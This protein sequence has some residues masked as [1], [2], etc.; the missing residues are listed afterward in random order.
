[1]WGVCDAT[2]H[3]AHAPLVGGLPKSN[4][5]S[6][7]SH[8]RWH[9]SEAGTKQIVVA[10]CLQK[11]ELVFAVRDNIPLADRTTYELMQAL[12]VQGWEWEPWV[13]QSQRKA[14]GDSKCEPYVR[15]GRKIWHST[16]TL[17]SHSYLIALLRSEELFDAG[18]SSLPHHCTE[19]QY[20]R[21]ANG[22]VREF[23]Q[24]LDDLP[25]DLE[26][27]PT[28]PK[29]IARAAGG[30]R[31]T[32]MPRIEDPE[33]PLNMGDGPAPKAEEPE[34]AD[35][36]E[37]EFEAEID[38]EELLAQVIEG[39]S[40]SAISDP[41][42]V[43][44]DAPGARAASAAMLDDEAMSIPPPPEPPLPL[45]LPLPPSDPQL[46][47]TRP[48]QDA[49]EMQQSLLPSG[50]FGVFRITPKQPGRVAGLYGGY[51]AD[52]KFHKKSKVTGCR[53]FI[54]L[55]DNTVQSRR[56]VLRRL[57]WWCVLAPTFDRQRAHICYPL[58]D[59]EIPD[60]AFIAPQK[61]TE[62][63]DPST[64]KTDVELDEREGTAPAANVRA[65]APRGAKQV[66]E[67]AASSSSAPA[68]SAGRGRGRV[69]TPRGRGRGRTNKQAVDPPAAGSDASLVQEAPPPPPSGDVASSGSS[70]DT[71]SSD[72]DSG[73]SSS[74]DSS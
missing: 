48:E 19:A 30:G 24:V 49:D 63:Q 59:D 38:L 31:S 2:H 18:L 57:M 3:G 73:S 20:R 11:P 55:P 65:R 54:T 64:V 67:Q 61:I 32:P 8:G 51:Q 14:R 21:L 53:R 40:A 4:M 25:P 46:E 62:A 66:G 15:G 28:P 41:E 43:G 6:G 5:V 47:D 56:A 26:E 39:N 33:V 58:V 44:A 16:A 70:S 72:S 34:S 36:D 12:S 60:L 45:P 74:S 50:R 42:D 10:T 1:M 13:P 35:S 29:K 7:L 71:S 22:E 9:L 23:M 52:C 68:A 17:P 37:G 69:A 27:D